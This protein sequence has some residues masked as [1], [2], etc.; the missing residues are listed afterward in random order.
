VRTLPLCN[1]DP[2]PGYFFKRLLNGSTKIFVYL[3]HILKIL[4]IS[5]LD[6][7]SQ[8]MWGFKL[9]V[10]ADTAILAELTKSNASFLGSSLAG[11]GL[12]V[13]H[14]AGPARL[15][16]AVVA[17]AVL[18]ADTVLARRLLAPVDDG[19]APPARPALRALAEVAAVPVDAPAVDA[20]LPVAGRHLR[21]AVGPGESLKGSRGSV[22]IMAFV[23]EIN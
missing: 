15:A 20:R 1:A 11:D 18:R 9:N 19:V 10:P 7:K 22:N 4:E 23:T 8:L 3:K 14:H 5:A 6:L 12:D 21:L 2:P 17:S 16:V 13:A